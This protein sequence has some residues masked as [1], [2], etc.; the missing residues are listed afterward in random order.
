MLR[1]LS[2]VRLMEVYERMKTPFR[3][4]FMGT[5]GFAVASLEALIADTDIEVVGV[6][7]V[8][9]KPA[10]RGQKLTASDVKKCAQKHGIPI[11][12]PVRLRDE[13]FLAALAAFRADLF[14]VVAFRMLPE[15]VWNMPP[16]GSINLHGSLLPDY[17]GA[18]PIHHAVMN[19][20]V[21]TG[22][23]TF[24]LNHAIDTGAIIDQCRIPIGTDDTTGEV[25]DR[26]MLAG[27]ELLRS[28]VRKIADGS[29]KPQ[30]QEALLAGRTPKEAPKLTREIA[31]INWHL[32]AKEVHNHIR[33]LSPFPCAWTTLNGEPVKVYRGK[34]SDESYGLAS[35][36][37]VVQNRSGLYVAC[38]NGEWY[39]VLDLQMPGK[40][41]LDV[42][43][44][45]AGRSIDGDSFA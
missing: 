39:S 5:P 36:G 40:K 35:P 23:T 42:G 33:G 27:A 18:A 41:R 22:C 26:M 15:V 34:V 13:D 1:G 7:T 45:I 19:G 6:V 38:A 14:V 20:E 4:V 28:T 24:F 32:P 12:Q 17:R 25:H 10:G 29:A 16:Y 9:D 37:S 30:S 8:A 44:F 11:L 2:L 43:S 3:I 31:R 21:E